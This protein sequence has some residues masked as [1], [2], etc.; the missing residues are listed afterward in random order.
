MNK[1]SWEIALPYNCA[2][3]AFAAYFMHLLLF[4]RDK[5][6]GSLELATA[7]WLFGDSFAHIR[8]E[9]SHAVFFDVSSRFVLATVGWGL[10]NLVI[11]QVA[12][13]N[14]S[15]Q[16][17]VRSSRFLRRTVGF[18]LLLV[19]FFAFGLWTT[20]IAQLVFCLRH[21][22]FWTSLHLVKTRPFVLMR[23][24]YAPLVVGFYLIF[25]IYPELWLLTPWPFFQ[26]EENFR[27]DL[28]GQY[29]AQPIVC[30]AFFACIESKPLLPGPIRQPRSLERE[31]DHVGFLHLPNLW[32]LGC[33]AAA[34]L[35]VGVFPAFSHTDEA[36]HIDDL[37]LILGAANRE[38][39]AKHR[40]GQQHGARFGGFAYNHSFS[41]L[42]TIDPMSNDRAA[43]ASAGM[44]VFLMVMAMTVVVSRSS[45]RARRDWTSEVWPE[46]FDPSLGRRG[47]HPGTNLRAEHF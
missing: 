19:P 9:T 6:P 21:G 36:S 29:M 3:L 14:S 45:K 47:R 42:R 38:L 28:F 27:V 33:V 10:C 34:I 23:S 2:V 8:S 22:C 5:H 41:T 11:I 31:S 18:T 24:V 40:L 1:S 15:S 25:R 17:I 32:L 35:A 16:W 30:L 12:L 39:L 7:L 43:R 13:H 20:Q 37:A 44:V 26:T 46:V 4:R